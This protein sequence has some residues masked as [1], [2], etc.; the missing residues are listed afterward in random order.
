MI[1]KTPLLIIAGPTASGKSSLALNLAK[2]LNTEIISCDSAQIYRYM[3]IGT[4]KP[5]LTE[6]KEV[7]HHLIDYVEP[8]EDYTAVRYKNDCDKAINLIREKGKT[9][10][11]CGGTGMYLNAVLY[12]MNFGNAYKSEE[13]RN[14]LND[15]NIKFGQDYLF[16]TLKNIDSKT[17]DT[18]HPNDVKRVIRAIEIFKVS[19]V[20]KSDLAE[21]YKKNNKYDFLFVVLNAQRSYL[22]DRINA[23]T[24]N[25]IKNGF[26][27]EV[28]KLKSMGYEKCKSMQAIGYR[29]ILEYLNGSFSLNDAVSYIKQFSRNYAKR[30]ITWFK[31]VENALWYDIEKGENFISEDIFRCLNS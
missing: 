22:Y 2:K 7:I 9:P 25:M 19:G 12:D 28:I 15:I 21:D 1:K 27:D 4:A 29:E 3:D 23:R 18:L 8:D 11:I 16:E 17:A 6:R 24:D 14:E 13:I 30:Q 5:D 26:V 10:I 31:G 20:K